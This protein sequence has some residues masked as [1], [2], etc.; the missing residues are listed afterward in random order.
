MEL[1]QRIYELRTQKNLSQGDLAEALDVSRQSISKWETGSSV[2]E[3]DKLI[4]LSQL[5]GVTLDE[6]TELLR[7]KD[8]LDIKSVQFAILETSGKVSVFL[9][10]KDRPATAEETGITAREQHLPI[11]IISDGK[12]LLHNLHLSG[13]DLS[14]VERTLRK[15]HSS[16]EETF[17]LTV[18]AAD[19][20]CWYP[21]E[22]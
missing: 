1:N 13:K 10:P 18:D 11:T 9:Y 12:L 20:I 3:L 6:L 14:W 17:L 4:K 22:G 5:F 8:V 21:K 7:E 16:L 2:P 15:K 19:Q